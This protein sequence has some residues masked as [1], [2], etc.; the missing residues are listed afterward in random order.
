MTS[1]TIA[2]FFSH[3]HK[4]SNTFWENLQQALTDLPGDPKPA[5]EGFY[6]ADYNEITGF[7]L[8]MIGEIPV[9][10]RPKY[11][12]FASKKVLQCMYLNAE[13]SQEFADETKEQYPGGVNIKGYA[14]GV[15]GHDS[16]IDEAISVLWL[17]S[18]Q[19]LQLLNTT[20]RGNKCMT[21][22]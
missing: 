8:E 4:R 5:C 17:F 1:G 6:F 7:T 12:Y 11:M 18:N 21:M 3:K 9:E 19:P 14:A 13:R 16:L 10:K 20:T 15:S 2:R 22:Q